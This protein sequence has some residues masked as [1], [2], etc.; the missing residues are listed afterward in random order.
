M[1]GS[2]E[3]ATG[4]HIYVRPGTFFIAFYVRHLKHL[5]NLLVLN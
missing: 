4:T 5:Y 3:Q 2:D 1:I